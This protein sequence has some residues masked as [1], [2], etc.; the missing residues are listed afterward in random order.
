MAKRGRK[1]KADIVIENLDKIKEMAR[2]GVTEE[3]I[4][5]SLGI[6]VST[7]EKYKNEFSELKESL[8]TSKIDL[9][10]TVK[11]ALVKRALGYEYEEKKQYI[12][13]DDNGNKKK[14]TEITT[15]H[16]PPDVGAINS[17]LQNIDDNWYRDKR[18]AE[19]RKQE[20]ELR[21]QMAEDKE[22]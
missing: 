3:E 6:S 17:L 15:K 7:F 22:W 12:T 2:V 9:S 14:H 18:G 10:V 20:L 19:L 13:E 21:K 1:S 4:A 8:K 16:M 5:K 11:S